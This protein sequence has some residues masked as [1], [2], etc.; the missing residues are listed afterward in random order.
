MAAAAAIVAALSVTASVQSNP[1]EPRP[2][3]D[4]RPTEQAPTFRAGVNFVRVDAV[5]TDQDGNPVLDLTPDDFEVTEGGKLQKIATFKL[6]SADGRV[7]PLE[8]SAASISSDAVEETEAARDEV[9]LF[10]IFLDDY[11][12][13]REWGHAVREQVARFVEKELGPSDMVGVMYPLTSLAS[14]RMTRN[15]ETAVKDILKFEGRKDDFTPK[16]GFEDAYVYKYPDEIPI[17]RKQVSFSALRGLIM[18][19]GGLKE[20]RQ[21]LLLV[22]EGYEPDRPGDLLSRLELLGSLTNFTELA[23]RTNTAIYGVHPQVLPPDR[24]WMP[25]D[26]M[27]TLSFLSDRSGGRAIFDQARTGA[28]MRDRGSVLTTPDPKVGAAALPVSH[29]GTAMKQ[30]AVDSSAYYLIGYNSTLSIPDDKYHKI[31]VRVKRPGFQVHHRQGYWAVRAE[32]RTK[33]TATP[34]AAPSIVAAARDAASIPRG[35]LV[36]TW[37]GMERGDRGLTRVTFAWEPTARIPGTAVPD[38]DR[39]ARVAIAATGPGGETY[40]SGR[41]PELVMET[42][43]GSSV[44]FNVP[45]GPVQ[46]RVRVEDPASTTLDTEI[47]DLRI[48]D[49]SA[50]DTLLGT[51]QVFR[52]ATAPDLQRLK[53]GAQ[54]SPAAGR[55][56]RRTDRLLIRVPAYGLGGNTPVLSAHLI[57]RSGQT[58]AELPVESSR[59]AGGLPQIEAPLANLGPGDYAVRILA[60]D[61]GGHA[62]EVVAFRVTN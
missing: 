10:A 39:P 17:I 28:E 15:H 57:N 61:A 42:T 9:R 12:V 22:S 11:H 33:M 23:N 55:E 51:P 25:T 5:V 52:A 41:V 45:P 59:I 18:H 36:R 4:P 20:G 2:S 6:L 44:S 16:N 14:I 43:R 50:P 31:D 30:I 47:V 54:A 35:R 34:A 21:S 38:S 53:E 48:A 27:D 40:F 3:Q 24:Q 58:V 19:L 1:Q 26:L 49:L 62:E 7:S 29:L 60:I 46:L 32:D 56:F 37:I 13:S 8:G